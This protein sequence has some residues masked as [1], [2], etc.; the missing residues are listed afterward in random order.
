M[1][2]RAT[3]L[4]RGWG[5]L[6]VTAS[7]CLVPTFLRAQD[8]SPPAPPSDSLI[9]VAQDRPVRIGA[10]GFPTIEPHL[11]ADPR[12]PGHLLAGVALVGRLGDPRRPDFEFEVKCAALTSFDAGVSWRRHDFSPRSCLDPWVAIGPGGQAVF[13]ALDGSRLVVFRSSDGGRTWNDSAAT[14]ERHQDHGTLSLDTGTG[15]FSGSVYAVSTQGVRLDSV[16]SRTAVFVARSSDWGATFAAPARVIPS[17]LHLV[18][19]NSVVLSDGTLVVAFVTHLGTTT[20]SWVI[21]SGDGGKSF[22]EPLFVTDVCGREFTHVVADASAGPHRDR[23]YWVCSDGYRVHV[24]RSADRGETWSTPVLVNRGSRGNRVAIPAIA[25]NRS[26]VVAVSWYDARDD[27]REY[28]GNFSC[29]QLFAS[30]SLHGGQTFVAEVKVSSTENCSDT[31]LNGEAGRRWPAGGD[32]HGLAA[33]ADGRFHV[34]WADSRD[35]LYQLRTAI[36]SVRG[37]LAKEP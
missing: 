16:R 5:P 14:L 1:G 23:I 10:T 12:D 11:A 13:L 25:V 26:G 19:M 28:R 33:A 17:N 9:V 34:M 35:G 3:T 7:V 32:Y 8:N 20:A 4:D 6:L 2:R 29:Q 24:L 31:P 21:R 36:I 18:A 30:A 37:D 27:P 22:S 15:P